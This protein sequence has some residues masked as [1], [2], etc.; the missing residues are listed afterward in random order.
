[1]INQTKITIFQETQK[2]A[3]RA[4]QN[5]RMYGIEHFAAQT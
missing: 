1:M 5:L 4:K 3:G 2:V